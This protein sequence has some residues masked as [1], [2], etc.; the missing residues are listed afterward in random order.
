MA[1][2]ENKRAPVRAMWALLIAGTAMV[3]VMA[4]AQAT[5][6]TSTSTV[7][8]ADETDGEILVTARTR[9][10][11]VQDVP[12]TVGV[13]TQEA[14]TNSG[15]TNLQQL[16]TVAPGLNM[17][18][19][20]TGNE[21]GV[22]IRGLGSAPGVP[23]FDS[24]VS[25]F[26]DGV[27]APRSREFAAS[28][29]DVE[30]IEVIRGTQAALLGKNTSLGAINLISR[31][32]GD[33]FAVDAR[34]SYEFERGSIVASGGIDIPLDDTL[35]LRVAG[36]YSH[37]N[38]FVKNVVLDNYAPRIRDTAFR[39]VL[40]WR[41]SDSF[42]VTAIVQHDVAWNYGNVVEVIASTGV[43][44]LLASLAGFPGVIDR[45][46]DRRA[47]STSPRTGGEQDGRLLSNKYS[48]AAN[49]EL[50]DHTLTS[51]TAYSR[52]NETNRAD[53][54]AV[55]G[56]YVGRTVDEVGTQFS[57]EVRIVS[58][59]DRP[60][61]YIVGG[62]YLDGR[63]DND[64]LF[65]ANMPFGPA[66]GVLIAG[67]Q[68]TTFVQD[69]SAISLF[70]Q[71]NYKFEGGF[72]LTGGIRWTRE[73]KD[74]DLARVVVVPGFFSTVIFPPY[75]PFSLSRTEKNFDYS[76]GVQYEI[77]PDALVY[78]SYGQGTKGGGYAQSVTRLETAGYQKEIART[79]EVG[80]KLQDPDRKWLLNVAAFDTKVDDFQLVTFTGIQFIVGNT[81]LKSRGVEVEA[82][83]KPVTGLRLF[84]NNTYA[85]AKDRA[86]GNPIP[87]APKWTGS[88]GFDY[89]TDVGANLRFNLNGSVDYRSKRYYQQNPATSPAGEAFTTLNL[90][91]ALGAEDDAWEVRLIGR[92]LTDANALSFSFP[93]PLLPAGNQGG[94]SER[95]RTVALQVSA[96]F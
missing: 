21:I 19:A 2:F 38:G 37:D 80:V 47:A 57:Q 96:H 30:R 93:L 85:D 53:G 88:G 61:D 27:Y 39:G 69:N 50:G 41:P 95:G 64:T 72:R 16:A 90:G 86:T 65:A 35:H 7:A 23:S 54:D 68:R 79:F 45:N 14:I 67:Q 28:L 78:A 32:P 26:V 59:S 36:S 18:K 94:M 31:K 12:A 42:D 4:S 15:A 77:S 33:T 25:L 55:P 29:F 92:N 9:A 66:P 87:L 81:D 17:T 5:A 46:L 91:V 11:S 74:V 84:I 22:T 40:V 76:F 73:T 62:L 58:P 48:L 6:D 49:L 1:V 3:P 44:E 56:D 24:S 8:A 82:S 52:Y 20:P 75:A 89:K 83:W 51:I 60:L 34:A 63:L 10:E 13:I 70:A 71:A 43:P